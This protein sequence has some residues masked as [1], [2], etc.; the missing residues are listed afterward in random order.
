MDDVLPVLSVVSWG[1]SPCT[2]DSIPIASGT[3]HP[4]TTY[5][6]QA[7]FGGSITNSGFGG[8]A[9]KFSRFYNQFAFM[10]G[11]RGA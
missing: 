9:I 8:I 3:S 2:G 4:T 11:G 7:L 5:K 1:P 10:T 6:A